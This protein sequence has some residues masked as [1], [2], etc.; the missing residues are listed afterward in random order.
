MLI[1]SRCGKTFQL[2]FY[3]TKANAEE[4]CTNSLKQGF[5][6]LDVYGDDVTEGIEKHYFVYQVLSPNKI[7]PQMICL[8]YEYHWGAEIN[9]HCPIKIFEIWAVR[10]QSHWIGSGVDAKKS[11]RGHRNF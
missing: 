10:I 8:V 9:I 6:G 5:K 7:F 3:R 4:A 11:T 2:K 1:L